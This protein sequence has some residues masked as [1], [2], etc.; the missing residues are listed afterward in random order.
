MNHE[1]RK[2][3]IV[4]RTM[5]MVLVLCW[6][7]APS[8]GIFE[9]LRDVLTGQGAGNDLETFLSRGFG[10]AFSGFGVPFA[11]LYL[12]QY[13]VAMPGLILSILVLLWFFVNVNIFMDWQFVNC[14]AISI[15]VVFIGLHLLALG[16]AWRFWS[17][18]S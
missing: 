2:T 11:L 17:T 4:I 3:R 7:V 14:R 12:L 5:G 6:S 18:F 13:R 8:I 15:H 10:I 1:E 16:F 9:L